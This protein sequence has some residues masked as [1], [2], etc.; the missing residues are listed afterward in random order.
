MANWF[1]RRGGRENFQ[2]L[3]PTFKDRPF[4]Y[5]ELG[6]FQGDSL[7]WVAENIATHPDSSCV[8]VDPW[9]PMA[10]RDQENMNMIMQQA[11]DRIAEFSQVKLRRQ[12]SSQYLRR[13]KKVK[14]D[15]PFDFVYIDGDHYA[16][17]V[18][19][20][21]VLVWPHIKDGG[22][23]LWDDYGLNSRRPQRRRNLGVETAVASFL[24]CFT[25]GDCFEILDLPQDYQFGVR[26]LRD[27]R[28]IQID[29]TGTKIRGQQ[30]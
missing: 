8:G 16:P 17:F 13:T 30:L 28:S 6:V 10:K 20:D 18:L 21:T 2:W 5:L 11:I 19:E 24:K 22:V 14:K 26:K 27:E 15:G 3:A 1:K 23:L 12:Y 7:A 29:Q 9:L 4:S 25:E